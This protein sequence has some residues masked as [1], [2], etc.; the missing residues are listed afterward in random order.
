MM[1]ITERTAKILWGR[2]GAVCSF[3]DCH[4]PLVVDGAKGDPDA[5]IGEM[6]HI[7]ADSPDGPRGQ[8]PVQG[9][10][11]DGIENLILLCAK[12]HTL[13]DKQQNQYSPTVLYEL[14][15]R[16]ER[17]VREQL[18]PEQRFTGVYAPSA[19]VIDR[20]QSAL[21][22]V[23]RLPLIV[24]GAQCTLDDADIKERLIYPA[25]ANIIAPYILQGRNLWTFCD[26]SAPDNPFS[27]CVNGP[28]KR[29]SARVWWDHPDR[30]KH[31]MWLLDR[32]LN[33]ITGHRGLQFD[34]AHHR[35]YFEPGEGGGARTETYRN[36]QGANE[37]R[38]VAWQPITKATQQP[39]NYW[40]HLA[41][42][43]KFH[44]VAP[45]SWCFSFRPER[46][47]TTDGYTPHPSR[48]TGR[49]ATSRASRLYN[50]DVLREVHFWRD[51]LSIAQPRIICTFGTQSLVIETELL[52]SE[53]TWP[54]VPDDSKPFRLTRYQEDLWSYAE[55]QAT[56]SPEFG[57]SDEW[58]EEDA[59]ELEDE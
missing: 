54:G 46:R 16:H 36:M 55:Y 20:V 28:I 19:P 48:E 38:Q 17:W 27:A 6:A 42:S 1:A 53:V 41:V 24:F 35:Y 3:P 5:V 13:V 30:S 21:L 45:S 18:A 37:R 50:H 39:K 52:A 23:T 14:K 2:A 4:Q 8:Y 9:G 59:W 51:Y 57:E 25:N 49:K 58:E 44:R 29:E 7:V 12:H 47:Y 31:Y 26:L 22:P 34:K 15:Q 10:D 40:E 11:R 32:T 33:K 56:L 43:L